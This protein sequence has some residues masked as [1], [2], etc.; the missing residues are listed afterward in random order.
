MENISNNESGEVT[1]E[2]VEQLKRASVGSA[3]AVIIGGS[4]G[5]GL[6]T[7]AKLAIKGYHVINISRS[8]CPSDRIESIQADVSQIGELEDAIDSIGEDYGRIDLL[9]YSAGFSMAAPVEHVRGED[10]RYLFEVNYFGA[11]RAIQTALP[12]MKENGGK[13]FLISSVGGVM[14]IPFDGFYSSSKAALDMLA[15]E[16]RIELKPYMVT[17]TSVQPGGTATSFTFRRKV[18][19][20]EENGRYYKELNKAV[21]ALG[22]M[23]QGGM[24]AVEVADCILEAVALRNP[25]ATIVCG[26]KNKGLLLLKRFMPERWMEKL[27]SNKYNQ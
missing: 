2:G 27:N 9:I 26:G 14:P 5:I 3:V 22:N 23:E 16:A 12:Y 25:P 7:G 8:V 4:S 1:E 6:E 18:Y 13:I 17:V 20:D 24:S 21:A 15:R 10:Y 19:S 11:L